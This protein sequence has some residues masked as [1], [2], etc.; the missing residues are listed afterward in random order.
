MKR[1]LSLLI[2][3]AVIAPATLTVINAS[4]DA[5]IKALFEGES[6][7]AKL[8]KYM[9]APVL[10]IRAE[11]NY[12]YGVA[13]GE[14]F[15]GAYESAIPLIKA[16]LKSRGMNTG[17][18]MEK[19]ERHA[20]VLEKYYPEYLER[21][22]GLSS[23]TGIGLLEL[24]TIKMAM[25]SM[26]TGCTTTASAPPATSDG[27]VYIT[28]NFDGLCLL[29]L[30]IGQNLPILIMND[31]PGC[32]KYIT[33][34]FMPLMGWDGLLNDKGLA[35][36]GNTVATTDA[37]DGLTCMEIVC[38]ALERCSNVHEVVEL[39]QSLPIFTSSA[40]SVYN[41]AYLWADAEGGIASIE[42]THNYF[43][44]NYGEDGILA[45]TNHHQWLD[46][47]LTGSFGREDYPSSY[48]RFERAW[49][50][51][52]EYRGS[53]DLQVI[54]KI[55]SDN[56]NGITVLGRE[57][58]GSNS[59]SC[60][61]YGDPLQKTEGAPLGTALIDTLCSIIIEPKELIIHWCPG[62]PD[63]LPFIPIYCAKLLGGT[64]AEGSNL[65]T[66]WVYGSNKAIE[67]IPL[68]GTAIKTIRMASIRTVKT[69]LEIAG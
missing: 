10:S 63:R 68:V 49:E 48:I 12:E 38:M 52:R 15:G 19:A 20:S 8:L 27:Q 17:E 26:L 35:F 62:H 6:H 56:A 47:N 2:A 50:L 61:H 16:F 21:L 13:V 23:S 46:R 30:W 37:G 11:S 34:S 53:I 5:P 32:N 51:L 24:L 57:I 54:K 44:V 31:I 43:A 65:M 45:H 36:S 3:I 39:M 67:T 40:M 25:P 29:K 1:V 66:F 69:I 64:G 42:C 58:G 22:E 4:E 41:L 60:H 9:G 55:V 14:I 33:V 59:I 28:W 7:T 18:A